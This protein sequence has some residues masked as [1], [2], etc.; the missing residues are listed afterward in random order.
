[1]MQLFRSVGTASTTAIAAF[2]I[3]LIHVVH[4]AI[5]LPRSITA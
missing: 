3:A 5:L 4:A 2:I 1:M